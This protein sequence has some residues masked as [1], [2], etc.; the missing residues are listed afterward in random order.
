MAA[1]ILLGAI[2]TLFGAIAGVALFMAAFVPSMAAQTVT[3]WVVF[4]LCFGG[5]IALALMFTSDGAA[6]ALMKPAGI[7]ILTLAVVAGGAAL[8][9]TIGVLPSGEFGNGSLWALFVS[10]LPLGILLMQGGGSRALVRAE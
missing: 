4:V 9:R 8:M 7:F 10:C 5:G 2:V 1:G 6:Y 3:L